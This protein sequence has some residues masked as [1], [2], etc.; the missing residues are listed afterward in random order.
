MNTRQ[1]LLSLLKLSYCKCIAGTR[2]IRRVAIAANIGSASTACREKC[3]TNHKLERET[4]GSHK[5]AQDNEGTATT[6]SQQ[7]SIQAVETA[8][9]WISPKCKPEDN[10]KFMA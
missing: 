10:F 6:P 3:S 2:K 5:N 8:W 4:S 7:S 1:L 9:S